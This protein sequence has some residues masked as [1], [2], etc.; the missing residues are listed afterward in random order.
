MEVEKLA[1]TKR[2][3]CVLASDKWR[4]TELLKKSC[5]VNKFVLK[6]IILAGMWRVAEAGSTRIR[7]THSK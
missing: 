1:R 4:A 2:K 7:E 6:K 3:K 5:Y